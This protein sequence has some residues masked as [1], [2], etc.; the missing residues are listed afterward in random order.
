MVKKTFFIVLLLF[1]LTGCQFAINKNDF[2]TVT[3][4]GKSFEV[5]VADDP[6]EREKGLSG[7]KK[8]AEDKGML[9]VYD[10]EQR[11][12][13]WMKGMLFPLDIIWIKGDRVVDLNKNI[14]PKEVQ[15]PETITSSKEVDKVLEV[16]SG[17]IEEFDIEIGDQVHYY[18]ENP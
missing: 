14:K 1:F 6:Q 3:I 15:P 7:R 10:K 2:S 4:S 16:N 13:F 17:V 11:P 5:E 9:F 8:L 12:E 18:K